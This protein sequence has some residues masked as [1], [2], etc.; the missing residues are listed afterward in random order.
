MA[1]FDYTCAHCGYAREILCRHDAKKVIHCS[2]CGEET[3]VRNNVQSPPV[4]QFMGRGWPGQEI[5]LNDRLK[6][7][8]IAS[9]KP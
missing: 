1:L 9:T 7:G 8:D 4:I 2:K 6:S 3:M 5:K